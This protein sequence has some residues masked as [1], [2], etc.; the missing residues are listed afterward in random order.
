MKFNKL[1]KL[2]LAIGVST[3]TLT[4]ATYGF[5]EINQNNVAE[6][7]AVPKNPKKLINKKGTWRGTNTYKSPNI[8]S[9]TR[10]DRSTAAAIAATI[11]GGMFGT[12]A[13][14]AATAAGVIQ[15]R[16]TKTTYYND[17]Y[18][19]KDGA[20]KN[21]NIIKANVRYFYTD[22]S[23]SAKAYAGHAVSYGP[24]TD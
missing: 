4:T 23:R 11:T 3:M 17:Y 9:D 24:V 16:G 12:V 7:K 21:G 13:G 5:T 19:Y 15:D 20:D 10:S 18:Y 6:A 1:A 2:S 14:G 22:S 8:K